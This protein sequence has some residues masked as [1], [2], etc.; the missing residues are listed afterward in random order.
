MNSRSTCYN[1]KKSYDHR[2]NMRGNLAERDALG[3]P[4]VRE[5]KKNWFYRTF[6]V[7]NCLTLTDMIHRLVPFPLKQ[8]LI[9]KLH[10][11]RSQNV[12]LLLNL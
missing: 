8:I 5:K 6:F 12:T 2:E 1:N 4:R 3:S 11:N 9:T 7:D 10:S